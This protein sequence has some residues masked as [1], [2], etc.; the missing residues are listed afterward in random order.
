MSFLTDVFS[1]DFSNLGNDL[2][3]SNI[4]KDFGSSFQNQP[5][6][7]QG[8]EIAVPAALAAVAAP[9]VLPGLFA[10]FGEAG[11]GVAA[12]DAAAG[13]FDLAT[14]GP[15]VTDAGTAIGS[16]VLPATA[17]LTEGT[18]P[19]GGAGTAFDMGGGGT[20]DPAVAAAGGAPVPGTPGAA[21]S[22][23]PY[24][25]V[26][27]GAAPT[28]PAFGAFGTQPVPYAGVTG[29]VPP[30]GAVAP[31][32]PGILSSIGGA[33]KSAAPYAGLAGLGLA[34]YQGYQ[35][36]Q[37]ID[38]L[39]AQEQQRTQKLDQIAAT[40]KKAAQPILTS[41]SDLMDYLKTGTLPQ[42]FQDQVT[43]SI[44][45]A[46]ARRIQAASN[47]GQSTDP[48]YNTALAQDLAAIDR[49]GEMLKTSL[50]Q[51]LNES[52]AQMVQTA[53]Q[54]LST[55]VSATDIAAQL[56]IMVQN[57]DMKLAQMT[58]QSIGA[59]AAAMNG[60]SRIPGQGG[61]FNI[62]VNSTTGAVTT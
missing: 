11:G 33:I 27:G 40:A 28:D 24:P 32:S 25:G 15:G 41:G 58:S 56:P 45:A 7:A 19:F 16:D 5:G 38:A 18:S 2:A 37:Q 59:F 14:I 26:T 42:G 44:N 30:P 34:G 9:E 23:I 20:V 49:Q 17:S 52:G 21:T 10:G 13:G 60:G 61:G 50:E 48:L 1:G 22:P 39:N 6:W 53:N 46:K 35:Q 47:M 31:E 29:G 57:L 43:Q 55:G 62:N 54:L 51:Q 12:A 36:K 3:P 8:L 4:F